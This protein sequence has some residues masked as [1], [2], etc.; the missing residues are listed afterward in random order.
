NVRVQAATTLGELGGPDA[1]AG[2]VRVLGGRELFAVRQQALVSLARIDTSAARAPIAAWLASTDWRDRATAVDA[3][4]AAGA[5]LR[6]YVADPDPRVI[7][8]ALQAWSERERKPGTELLAAA[9]TLISARDAA[10]RSVAADILAKAPDPSDIPALAAAY[11]ASSSDSF[12]EAAESALAAL[13]AVAR[14][15]DSAATRVDREFLQRTPRPENYL[16]RR[17]AEG[18][19]PAA[20]R[21][22]GAAFPI[23]TNRTVQDYRE[24]AR[25]FIFGPDAIARPHVFIEVADRGII[26]IELLGR[27]APLTVANFLGLVDRHYFDGNRWHRV[28]PNFVIQD[29]DRRGDGWGSPG[30]AIRDE[31]NRVRYDSPVLGMA[32]SGPDTGSGQWFINLSPQPHLDGTYTVFG[33]LAGNIGPLTRVTQGDLIRTIRR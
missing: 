20:A 7:A 31:I 27:D 30:G 12:P 29:G 3:L 14:G 4:A 24:I 22:W 6:P 15:S 1:V 17:W 13:A 26:D 32:L 11:V 21:R 10:V 28:V 33:R 23:S 25:R 16:I 19:W 5:S 9:R 2:L 8:T 18:R